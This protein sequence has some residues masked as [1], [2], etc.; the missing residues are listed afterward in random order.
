M[1]ESWPAWG[2][3]TRVGTRSRAVG[4]VEKSRS[5]ATGA[6]NTTSCGVAQVGAPRVPMSSSQRG[7]SRGAGQ[8][9]PG[10]GAHI[11]TAVE[12]HRHG[13]GPVVEQPRRAERLR[14]L[15]GLGQ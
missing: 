14:C 1:Q 8:R 15:R 6:S 9:L 12:P 7:T 11:G 10:G 13:L 5:R 3:S 4:E 2:G